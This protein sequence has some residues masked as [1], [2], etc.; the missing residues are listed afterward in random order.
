MSGLGIN[1][2]ELSQTLGWQIDKITRDSDPDTV[3]LGMMAGMV[4]LE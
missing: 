2:F 4:L 1:F 3:P